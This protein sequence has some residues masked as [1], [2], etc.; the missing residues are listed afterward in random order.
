MIIYLSRFLRYAPFVFVELS[1]KVRQASHLLCQAVDSR[2]GFIRVGLEL[3]FNADQIMSQ[4]VVVPIEPEI[5]FLKATILALEPRYRVLLSPLVL[6][7]R[8]RGKT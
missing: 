6:C 2:I 7:N 3:D 5:R 4:I 1:I 8:D